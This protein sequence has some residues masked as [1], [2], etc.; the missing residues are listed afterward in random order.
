MHFI[1]VFCHYIIILHNSNA[2]VEYS[3]ILLAVRSS[4]KHQNSYSYS[5]YLTFAVGSNVSMYCT[6]GRSRI[7]GG[8]VNTNAREARAKILSHAHLIK[9][10]PFNYLEPSTVLCPSKHSNK[11]K[12]SG[13]T[14]LSREWFYNSFR[15]DHYYHQALCYV[16]QCLCISKH[17]SSAA[18]YTVT[19]TI[20]GGCNPLN[21]P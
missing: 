2:E 12:T 19:L 11:C 3:L 4:R 20:W 14:S 21:P 15:T 18:F 7:Y 9:P 6:R 17:I 1:K 13:C 5:E 10:H 16:N 8:V